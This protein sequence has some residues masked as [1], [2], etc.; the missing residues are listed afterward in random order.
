[1]LYRRIKLKGD[2]NPDDFETRQEFAVSADGTRVPMFIVQRAGAPL[3]GKS[4]TLLYGYG[5][6]SWAPVSPV[7]RVPCV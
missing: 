3:E 1:M 4:P 2:F 5:G 6:T 7:R